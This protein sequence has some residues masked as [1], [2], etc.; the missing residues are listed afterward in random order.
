[1]GEFALAR[2]TIT[3]AIDGL[4]SAHRPDKANPLRYETELFKA[5]IGLDPV[6][7]HSEYAQKFFNRL[8]ASFGVDHPLT[9]E[10]MEF[11]DTIAEQHESDR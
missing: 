2:A 11:V 1:M 7:A 5:T 9:V 8:A 4:K 10:V 3:P 6:L